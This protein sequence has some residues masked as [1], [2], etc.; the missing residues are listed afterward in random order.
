MLDELREGDRARITELAATLDRSEPT[1]YTSLN[2]LKEKG[3]VEKDGYAYRVSRKSLPRGEYARNR[4][5]LDL[6]GR[7]EVNSLANEIGEYVHRITEEQGR[8][9]KLYENYGD[10]VVAPSTTSD[11][12]NFDSIFTGVPRG[13]PF[14]RRSLR[15]E[16]TRSSMNTV[17][18]GNREHHYR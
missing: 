10:V 4:D 18:R 17:P 3:Y 6:A 11:S 16:S 7:D 1:I 12:V 5:E 15:P 2:T 8:Q 13:K 9:I 14:W